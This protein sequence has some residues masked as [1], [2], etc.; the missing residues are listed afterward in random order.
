MR[1]ELRDERRQRIGRIDVDPALRPTR[2]KIVESGREVFL[3]W[4]TALDDAGRLRRCVACGCT[5][6][7]AEKVFPMVTGVVVVLAFVGFIV[8]ALGFLGVF[9]FAG[10]P[11]ILVAMSVILVMDVAILLF[12]RRRLVCYRCRSSF[13]GLPIA[14]YHRSWDSSVAERHPPPPVTRARR[15]GPFRRVTEADEE[16]PAEDAPPVNAVVR[17]GTGL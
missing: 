4:E 7:F 17:G 6:I 3:N 15:A 10:S 5:D 14:R 16:K 13:H 2:V 12:S 11:H 8:G 9:S 1:I